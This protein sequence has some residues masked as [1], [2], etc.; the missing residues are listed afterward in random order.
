MKN[1]LIAFILII[2]SFLFF[3]FSCK[4]NSGKE[5]LIDAKEATGKFK[6]D[7]NYSPMVSESVDEDAVIEDFNTEEYDKINE[8]V[9]KDTLTNPVSTFSIDVDTASYSNVR[10]YLAQNSMP[11]IDSVRIEELINY[12]DY[13]YPLPEG[14]DPFSVNLEMSKCPWNDKHNLLRIGLKGKELAEETAPPSNLVF[15]IDVSG[16]MDAPNKLDLL[17]AGY[18]ILVDKLRAVDRVAIVV[19]AGAAGVV[20]D[21]TTGDKKNLIKSAINK[22]MAGGSTAGSAGI[23]L[24]YKVAKEGFIPNGNNR[25]ILATDGDF[26]VG[27]SSD[28]E[29]ERM[30]EEKRNDGIF[31]TILGFGMYNLKDAKMEKMTNAGNGTYHYIDN[32]MEAKKVLSNDIWGTL[33][34]IAKDV[35]IQI[36]FNPS[37]IKGYRLVGYENRLLNK[38]DFN[39][40]KKDAGDI[41]AGHRVT[42]FYEIIPAESDETV[43]KSDNLNYQKTTLIDSEDMMTFKMRYKA[44]DKDESKLLEKKVTQKDIYKDAPSNEFLFAASVA[45]FGLLLRNS[46]FKG[47]STYDNAKELAKSNKGSDSY[48]YRDEFIRLI[49]TAKILSKN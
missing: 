39:D 24:A 6:A 18:K 1:I 21:S 42:A 45:Q 19:Y 40:D 36:E 2:A 29:M 11:P 10:R 38:E 28:S 43:V 12:F 35:K 16:S 47:T 31:L 3:S 15:L 25:V 32:V 17:K 48:G 49:E 23:E 41:G 37:K 9:F 5:N 46:E 27:P 14:E 44:P 20:L 7:I 4:G 22:L 30:I 8:N 34:T 33:F 13:D 26:N